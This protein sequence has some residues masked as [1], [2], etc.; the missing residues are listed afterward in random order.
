MK[1]KKN[2]VFYM[3][4]LFDTSILSTLTPAE[5]VVYAAYLRY[6]NGGKDSAFPSQE[7]LAQHLGMS[8]RTV[9]RA[10]SKLVEK[11]YIKLL[12]S[13]KGR[14]SKKSSVYLVNTP[15]QLGFTVVK[16]TNSE[17]EQV[18]S[19]PTGMK[20]GTE[21][22]DASAASFMSE[23]NRVTAESIYDDGRKRGNGFISQFKTFQ[24][25]IQHVEKSSLRT[26]MSHSE[27]LSSYR[28]DVEGTHPDWAKYSSG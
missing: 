15:S 8:R 1:H 13:G 14:T 27:M 22:T 11:N 9:G 5:G 17:V 24:D 25:L 20:R 12:S 23:S 16:P 3:N 21:D 26:G 6:S 10:V 18:P 7:M 4:D 19:T 28:E 2:E